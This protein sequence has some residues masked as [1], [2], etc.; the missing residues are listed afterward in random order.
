MVEEGDRQTPSLAVRGRPGSLPP[1]RT[2]TAI[3][4]GRV[5]GTRTEVI[6]LARS[7]TP[8]PTDTVAAQSLFAR[9]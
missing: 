3:G 1:R 2:A 9:P 6:R 8:P 5:P 4:L 7:Q